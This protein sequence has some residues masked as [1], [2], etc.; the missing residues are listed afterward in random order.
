M[1]AEQNCSTFYQKSIVIEFAGMPKS[2]KTTIVDRLSQLLRR[3]GCKVEEFHG[4]GRY[5]P[6]D[7][8]HIKNL[9]LYL[10]SSTLQH[11]SKIDSD[12]RPARFHLLDRG[13]V[14][15]AIFSEALFNLGLVDYSHVSLTHAALKCKGI[16]NRIR[17]I[18]VFTSTTQLSLTRDYRGKIG[19]R[20]G[21]VMNEQMLN[22]LLNA[23]KFGAWR[24]NIAHDQIVDIDTTSS[25]ENI[26]LTFDTVTQS[27]IRSYPNFYTL[28]SSSSNDE[29]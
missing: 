22:A 4:G 25:D 19:P 13:L 28:L 5:A 23:A 24:D 8:D 26:D 10:L 11:L 27:I 12:D 7:K 9:N 6:I 15:R 1:L 17:P 2:G 21:R 18:F 3:T 20:T 14:D 29:I 16:I